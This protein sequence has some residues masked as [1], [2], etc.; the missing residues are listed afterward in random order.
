MY[1]NVPRKF[2]PVLWFEQHVVANEDVATKV[3]L[4][5]AGPLAGQLLGISFLIIGVMLLLASWLFKRD[6]YKIPLTMKSNLKTEPQK[7]ESLPLVK[8]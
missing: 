2:M 8:N 7:P 1:K 4:I 3:K 6:E 5:L